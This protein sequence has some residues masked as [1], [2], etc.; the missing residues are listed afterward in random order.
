MQRKSRQKCEERKSSH[1]AGKC[2]FSLSLCC[3]DYL[4]L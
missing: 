4:E 3:T 2:K 1:S